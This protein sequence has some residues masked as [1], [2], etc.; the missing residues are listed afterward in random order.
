MTGRGI[1]SRGTFRLAAARG[2]SLVEMLVA[3]AVFLII[4]SAAFSLFSNQQIL[5]SQQQGLAGLNIGV[6]NALT[7][8]QMDAVNG[9]NGLAL[10]AY[11]PSWPVGVK[12]VNQTPSTACNTGAPNYQFGST[13]FDSLIIIIADRNTPTC[14]LAANLNTSTATTVNVIPSDGLAPGTYAGNFHTGDELMVVS[15]AGTPFTTITLTANGTVSGSAIAL[16]FTRTSAPTTSPSDP[17]GINPKDSP[18]PPAGTGLCLTTDALPTYRGVN[19][20][21]SSP[22]T[23][24]VIRLA[25]ITYYV[26]TTNP[27]DPK[28]MRQVSGG[29]ATEVMD[30]VVTFKVGAALENDPTS[31]YY[32]KAS[33][34]TNA[35][36]GYNSDFTLVRSIRVTLMARTVPNGAL[37]YRNGFDGGPYQV[38]GSSV[39]VNPRNM[40]MRDQ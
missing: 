38:L 7:Q 33:A 3:I 8:I 30:Q 20:Y 29:T 39:V 32:Y 22:T 6:R 5:L 19:F 34:A 31:N 23:D 21:Q 36:G 10:G 13:C 9:A 37:P 35:L 17:G 2:F 15:G 28:L 40:S 1:H 14:N 16:S 26:D 25:P 12:V 24:W 11:A 4:S 27:N 18:C